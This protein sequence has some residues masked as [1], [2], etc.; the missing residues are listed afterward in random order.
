MQT[1]EANFVPCNAFNGTSTVS[2]PEA[3]SAHA[4]I[5]AL[6]LSASAMTEISLAEIPCSCN[7]NIRSADITENVAIAR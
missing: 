3:R 1:V 7:P 5:A 4:M 6:A 2:A